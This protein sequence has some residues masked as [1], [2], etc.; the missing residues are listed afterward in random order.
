MFGNGYDDDNGEGDD[1]D[2]G[3]C[4]CDIRRDDE[5]GKCYADGTQDNDGSGD[6]NQIESNDEGNCDGGEKDDDA[7]VGS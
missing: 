3:K 1:G 2:S 5:N 6:D 4:S 7:D